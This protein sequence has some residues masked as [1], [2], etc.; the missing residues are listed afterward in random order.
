GTM[1]G[2]T[3]RGQ[4]SR[5]LLVIVAFALGIASG[6][7]LVRDGEG[8]RRPRSFTFAWPHAAPEAMAPRGGTTKGPPVELDAAPGDAW[9]RLRDPALGSLERDRQA[10][11]AM[12]GTYRTSFDFLEVA[13]FRPG[14]TPDRPYQSW[15]T[16][17]VYVVRDEPRF[18]SLQHVL[19][20]FLQGRD[21]AVEGPFVTKHWRQDWRY[22]DTELLTYRGHETWAKRNL[23]R[24]SMNRGWTQAVFQVDDSPRYEAFGRWRHFGN[25]ST[26][27]S[28]TTWRPLP[29][30]E[31]SVRSDY[32][33]LVG[34]NRVT[35]TPTGWLQEEDN[36]KVA[37]DETGEPVS[38][39][40][41][42]AK[43]IGLVRY[44]RLKDFD[45]S[46]GRRYRERTEP[47]WSE[48]RSAWDE[49]I[50]GRERLALRAA[51][52]QSEL[53]VPLFEYAEK[54][55]EGAPFDPA[56]ARA[57]ARETVRGY[58]RDDG[59]TDASTPGPR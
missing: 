21:G 50:A 30:R 51:P 14:F 8:P 4:Q 49:L 24:R 40:P 36:L 54:L 32:H 25:V 45:D 38:G 33:V 3:R 57:F 31:F 18:I 10:I 5:P 15:A 34:K 1:A 9:R 11:L 41:V 52:D 22:E 56:A 43:E 55:D 26:W 35:I 23:A 47:F 59:R 46:A 17:Y 58:L 42:L 13:G 20:T 37:L 44:E 28:S 53:F 7:A 48:V 29:R 39:A 12:A 27:Q 19:V 16:E 6:F 2:M